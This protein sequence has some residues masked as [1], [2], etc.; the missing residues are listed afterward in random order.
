[1]TIAPAC[2]TSR[3][4]L[5][6]STIVLS[7]AALSAATPPA[8]AQASSAAPPPSMVSKAP[9]ASLASLTLPDAP[10]FSSHAVALDESSSSSSPATDSPAPRTPTDQQSIPHRLRL[11]TQ[12]DITIQP[13]QT[14]PSLTA[15]NKFDLGLR[16]S[17]TIFSVIGW[18]ASAGY[19]QLTNGSPNYGTDSGAFGMRLGATG[20]RN[21]SHNILGNAIFAPLFHEDPRYYRLGDRQSFLKRV[22]YAGTRPLI[23]RTDSGHASPNF[24]LLSGDLA[25]AALTNLYYPQINQGPGPTLKTFGTSVGGSA[26]GFVVTEF[27][28]DVLDFAHLSRFE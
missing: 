15:R 16:E 4:L 17:F 27:L 7:L 28:N 18:T 8:W 9:A 12:S 20:L 23:T 2:S 13:G 5:T 3:T 14:A 6:T 24:S 26:V 25:G 11:A 22:I 1:M 19:S 21:T 10:G